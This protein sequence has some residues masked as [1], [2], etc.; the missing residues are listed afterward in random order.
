MGAPGGYNHASV[1]QAGERRSSSVE[2]LRALAAL[3]VLVFHAEFVTHFINHRPAMHTTLDDL[4]ATGAQG[5]YLFFT[6]TAYLLFRPFARRAWAG[7]ERVD[8]RRYAWNR[9]VRILPLYYVAIVV[10]LVLQEHGGTATQW[11]RFPLLLQNFWHDSNQTVDGPLWS[12]VV[13]LQFYVLLPLLAW[14]IARGTRRQGGIA[15]GVL[16]ILG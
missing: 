12:V 10:L 13:E 16:L 7:G 1:V 5:V 2:S 6:L 15:I 3:V 9:V 8:L 11:W 14:L 4:V